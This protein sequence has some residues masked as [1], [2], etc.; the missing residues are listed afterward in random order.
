MLTFDNQLTRVDYVV[1][2]YNAYYELDLKLFELLVEEAERNKFKL[3]VDN[4]AFLESNQTELSILKR[5][6][7]INKLISLKQADVAY[8]KQNHIFNKIK[9]LINHGNTLLISNDSNTLELLI[10][11]YQEIEYE[12]A[13]ECSVFKLEKKQP[14]ALK[15]FN[16]FAG[17]FNNKPYFEYSYGQNNYIEKILPTQD[18]LT[19]K[20]LFSKN[21]P[22]EIDQKLFEAGESKIYSLKNSDLIFKYFKNY[23][24]P[25]ALRKLQK[26]V[27]YDP[28][29]N[30]LAWPIGLVKNENNVV[31]GYTMKQ[32]NGKTLKQLSADISSGKYGDK[33]DKVIQLVISN[34][35]N[36]LGLVKVMYSNNVLIGDINAKNI[37]LTDDEVYLVDVLSFQINNYPLFARTKKYLPPE[38][39]ES[40]KAIKLRSFGNESYSILILLKGWF[41]LLDNPNLVDDLTATKKQ[42][43]LDLKH[44]IE[45]LIEFPYSKRLNINGYLNLFNEFIKKYQS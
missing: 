2:D 15:L 6:K 23:L 13:E 37:M 14:V 34:I 3:I 42:L 17:K 5:Y 38:I 32:L 22:I 31:L 9:S 19:A 30:R 20:L 12:I 27:E 36:Y 4:N 11:H 1:L 43:Y 33:L 41:S 18:H 45:E 26:M 35:L 25:F 24:H 21:K 40:N 28:I 39:L 10:K 29:D 16:N 8:I 44:E 7:G